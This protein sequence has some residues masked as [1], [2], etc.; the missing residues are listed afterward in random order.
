MD[1]KKGDRV[2]ITMPAQEPFPAG[3]SEGTVLSAT[4]QG[5]GR[6]GWYIEMTKDKASPGWDLGYGYWKQE[7]DGGT[8]EKLTCPIQGCTAETA[9]PYPP[10][11]V[12][13]KITGR[14][15]IKYKTVDTRTSKGLEEAERLHASGWKI[16]STGLTTIQFYKINDEG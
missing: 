7:V 5:E 9:V 14:K 15:P 11:D 2:R 13:A 8:V 10:E 4:N 6:G 16:G 12:I 3:W 1:I